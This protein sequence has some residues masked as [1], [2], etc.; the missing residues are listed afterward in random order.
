MVMSCRDV[1]SGRKFI[2][3]KDRLV[4]IYP[5]VGKKSWK[6]EMASE[7]YEVHLSPIIRT[8]C[9]DVHVANECHIKM[10]DMY[11]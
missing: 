2:L 7:V 6:P 8:Y 3:H 9:M 10:S 4:Q 11:V 5:A 1:K